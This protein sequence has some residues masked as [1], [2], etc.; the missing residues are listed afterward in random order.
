MNG[1]D[2]PAEVKAALAEAIAQLPADFRAMLPTNSEGRPQVEI[3]HALYRYESPRPGQF[4]WIEVREPSTDEWDAAMAAH[5]NV[6]SLTRG[7]D[8]FPSFAWG[9]LRNARDELLRQLRDQTRPSEWMAQL[10]EYRIINYSTALKLYHEH[11]SAQVKRTADD[12]VKGQVEAAFSETYDRS[13]GYRL[14]YWMCNAFQH[15][16]RGLVSLQ[17]TARPAAG[18]DTE[19]ES[20]AYAHLEKVAFAAS[21]ANAAVRRQIREVDDDIDLF[22]LGEEAFAEARALNA[23]LTPLLHPGAPAAAQCSC[24]T[25]RNSVENGRTFTCM[26]VVFRRGD[27]LRR[28]AWTVSGLPTSPD[29]RASASSTKQ[30]HRRMR[31]RSCP[32]ITPLPVRRPESLSRHGR[33]TQ[34]PLPRRRTG[35]GGARAIPKSGAG[36]RQGIPV[37]RSGLRAPDRRSG[38]TVAGIPLGLVSKARRRRGH[39]QDHPRL[40]PAPPTAS[41]IREERP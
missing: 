13:F 15:G 9:D 37:G 26:S 25:S 11:V 24:S 33:R 23:R 36:V 16:V 35:Y 2:E 10:I 21:R 41:A 1:D 8:G 40:T 18:S 20:E 38:L 39:R 27:S 32:R 7:L 14:M 6:Y 12:D 31:W 22:E 17:M 34:A 29:R 3:V 4:R 28:G 19:R 30:G 5:G